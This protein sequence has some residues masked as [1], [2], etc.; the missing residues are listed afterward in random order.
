L[1][2]LTSEMIL[3]MRVNHKGFTLIEIIAVLI[4]LG[5]LAAVALPRYF[6]MQEDSRKTALQGAIA[7]GHSNLN[8]AYSRFL[9][10]GGTNATITGGAITGSGGISQTLPTDMA[11]FTVAYSVSG[12][13]CTVRISGTTA[14]PWVGGMPVEDKEKTLACPWAQHSSPSISSIRISLLSSYGETISIILLT[15]L[16]SCLFRLLEFPLWSSP[17]LRMDGEPLM[18]AHDAY[19]WLAGA[20]GVNEAAG[21]PLS[22]V[23]RLLHFLTDQPLGE[24]AFWLPVFIAP[25]VVIPVCI[26]VRN[27]RMPEAGLVAGILTASSVG[28]LPRTRLG[29]LDT[30]LGVLFFT[31]ALA[32][33]FI[34]WLMPLCREKWSQ[35]CDP[36]NHFTSKTDKRRIVLGALGLGLLIRLFLW[37]YYPGNALVFALFGIAMPA[38][39][40][41]CPAKQRIFLL[42]TF[43]IIAC[44]WLAGWPGLIFAVILSIAIIRAPAQMARIG[45]SLS[46]WAMLILYLLFITQA[47]ALVI[48]IIRN[49]LIAAKMTSALDSNVFKYLK[50]PHGI[51]LVREALDIPL[52]I[53]IGEMLGHWSYFFLGLIGFFWLT[54]KRPL[55]ILFLP[56]IFLA[57]ASVKLGNRFTMFA[58]VPWGLG[59]GCG[60]SLVM[61]QMKQSKPRRYFVMAVLTLLICFPIW[62]VARIMR[63]VPALSMMNAQTLKEMKSRAAPDAELW[64]WWDYGYAAQYYAE[65]ITFGDGG[66][67]QFGFWLYPSALVHATSSPLQ[68]KQMMLFMAKART[69]QENIL[70]ANERGVTQ[71]KLSTSNFDPSRPFRQLKPD[72]LGNLLAQLA[73]EPMKWPSGMREQYLTFSWDNLQR[74]E[75]ISYCANWDFAAGR[76]R[77]DWIRQG[78]GKASIDR[79][80]GVLTVEHKDY[81]LQSLDILSN[82]GRNRLTWP[83]S[84]G[85][86]AIVN[87][88]SRELYLM[89]NKIYSSLMIRM[90]IDDT[91]S[92]A[93]HFEIVIDHFPWARSYRVKYP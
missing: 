75:A 76:G 27:W 89:D 28:F 64:Q 11:D 14:T 60:L 21:H 72:E 56:F 3:V 59:L 22:E 46:V 37:F 63:P 1:G 5:I 4:I 39:I 23:L 31:T 12:T 38:G 40:Y 50:V 19:Y 33:G 45:V 55:A 53:I 87:E 8:L 79:A 54:W 36:D 10:T 82:M 73:N 61:Q 16:I 88:L 91:R 92:F 58:G 51:E 68:A 66:G 17:N 85:V 34:L 78:S 69:E 44:I 80:N 71:R 6:N 26:L 42:N 90:L 35:I 62:D 93:D 43:V 77:S 25:L 9:V 86:H 65:R 13:N 47:G 30:D 57:L 67:R 20:K 7:A 15:Y 18:V 83:N 70:K 24:I 49:I 2:V 74:A 84:Q 32:T 41:L 81:R 29:Y 48:G 52:N